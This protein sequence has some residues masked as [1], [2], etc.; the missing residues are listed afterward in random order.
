MLLR[1]ILKGLFFSHEFFSVTCKKLIFWLLLFLSLSSILH[2]F[3]TMW[4]W[5]Y[6][7]TCYPKSFFNLYIFAIARAMC[8]NNAQ[9]STGPEFPWKIIPHP[10]QYLFF[11][12]K[13]RH[14]LTKKLR[15]FWI[16]FS[17]VNSTNF[18]L[19]WIFFEKEIQILTL[20]NE[21]E[22]VL[23]LIW[24]KESVYY[25]FFLRNEPLWFFFERRWGTNLL[26]ECHFFVE[27]EILCIRQP[28]AYT[29]K[30]TVDSLHKYN[31]PIE[32]VAMLVDLRHFLEEFPKVGICWRSFQK[33]H[34]ATL[35]RSWWKATCCLPSCKYLLSCPKT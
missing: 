4:M 28:L 33:W 25:N 12:A 6:N 15:R 32:E 20:K 26:G 13:F 23:I 14:V 35:G 2:L 8:N 18:F 1:K 11:L 24:Y 19:F 31:G 30:N 3:R 5:N 10:Y 16:F 7:L 17:I 21:K 34:G 22:E 27:A 29:K 9:M